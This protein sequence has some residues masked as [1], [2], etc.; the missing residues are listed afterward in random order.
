MGLRGG[1]RQCGAAHQM[2]SGEKAL[3]DARQKLHSTTLSA[4]AGFVPVG[5]ALPWKTP[6]K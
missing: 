6:Q 1:G 2:R 4:V 5:V 3:R